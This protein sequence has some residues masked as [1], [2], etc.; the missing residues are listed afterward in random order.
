[1]EIYSKQLAPMLTAVIQAGGI[2]K[3]QPDGEFFERAV[4]RGMLPYWRG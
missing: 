4:C 3:V 1:M 2:T